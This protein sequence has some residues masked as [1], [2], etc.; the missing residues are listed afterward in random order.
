MRLIDAD[1]L[2]KE[3]DVT[4]YDIPYAC[5]LGK[6]DQQPT[7]SE[8]IS[9]EHGVPDEGVN[10]WVYSPT[11]GVWIGHLCDGK[12]YLNGFYIDDVKWWMQLPELP[13]GESL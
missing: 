2:K 5:S 12:W 6:I 3:C 1:K 13:E 4:M 11:V 10:V 9:V 8:W 7:V